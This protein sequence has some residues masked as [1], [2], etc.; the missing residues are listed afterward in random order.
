[1]YVCMY[2]GA[3]LFIF[4]V[5]VQVRAHVRIHIRIHIHIHI[6][7]G[8]R[9]YSWG[10]LL[11]LSLSLSSHASTAYIYMYLQRRT[12]EDQTKVSQ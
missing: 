5:H 9:C 12:E 4:G 2:L 1:M 11:Q 8:L 3:C 7:T 10:A 6:P